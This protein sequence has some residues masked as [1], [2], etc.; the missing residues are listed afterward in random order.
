MTSNFL[1]KIAKESKFTL[2]PKSKMVWEIIEF[3]G[4]CNGTAHIRTID[5]Y[6]TK[7]YRLSKK[8]KFIASYTLVYNIK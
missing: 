6:N 1:N 7:A 3:Q 5:F 4:L 2:S 8:N